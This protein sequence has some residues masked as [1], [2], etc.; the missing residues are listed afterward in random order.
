MKECLIFD[1]SHLIFRSYH[2][3][4]ELRTS[5][6]VP[7]QALY[8]VVTSF[9]KVVQKKPE[10][11]IVI[12]ADGP[13]EENYRKEIY[14]EY[15]SNRGETPEDLIPQFQLI[16]DFF[17]SLELPIIKVKGYEADD[18]IASFVIQNKNN[19]DRFLILSEDK[20]LYQL[21]DEKTFLWSL[22]DDQIIDSKK[23]FEK[24]GVHPHQM[25]DYLTLV[26]DSSDHIPG[27]PGIGKEGA[28]KLLQQFSTLKDIDLNQIK[29]KKIQK[30][31]QEFLHMDLTQELVLLK[32][33]LHLLSKAEQV[34]LHLDSFKNF[35]TN[36]EF[37]SLSKKLFK[38]EEKDHLVFKPSLKNFFKNQENWSTT[39]EDSE[40]I[41]FILNKAYHEQID[42]ENLF[43]E[44]KKDEKLYNLYLLEK[45]ISFILAK[46]ETHGILINEKFY[47]NLD[48]EWTQESNNLSKKIF[49]F[50]QKEINLNSP[51]QLAEV[52]FQEMKFPVVRKTKTGY[53]TDSDVLEKLKEK[54]HHEIFDLL[55]QYREIE[56]LLTT[57][58][59]N[60]LQLQDEK[61]RLHPTFLQTKV[62][63]G[64][65][66][67]EK[68]N[69]QNIPIKSS[70]GRSL[71]KGFIAPAHKI[72]LSADY[73]QIEL[74]ILAHFSEDPYLIETFQKDGDI[75][76]ATAKI[77]FDEVDD[78]KRNFAKMINFSL[79]YGQ[80]AQSLAENL[81]VSYEEAKS[82]I[83]NYFQKF[84][85]VK[86]FIESLKDQCRHDS[87]VE[88]LLGRRRYL[89]EINSSQAFIRS[90]AERAAVN[91][92]IQGTAADLI[93]LSMIKI[94]EIL[95]K[96][97]FLL[98]QIHDELI[99]ECPEEKL[100]D[101]SFQVK[102]IMESIYPLKIPLKVSL[103]KG[104]NLE[105]QERI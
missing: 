16:E 43:L 101:F 95:P 29:N 13:R 24:F 103:K 91:T 42:I 53:S 105:E 102:K 61:H 8:G 37:F 69:L 60:F 45:K 6:G 56:K 84:T 15:K 90:F 19:F 57:Y 89:P 14:Q 100:Q 12:A 64:R 28:K 32:K 54:T 52:L 98:L 25:G 17:K 104:F 33:D 40:L 10:A 94:Y 85:K 3:L 51:K 77:L 5:Q 7:V 20:D 9:I 2:A 34:N 50:F 27:V 63:T 46:M 88:T 44:L 70:L 92:P 30:A 35:L 79:L 1:L 87:Y 18:I 75:H 49:S 99:F 55:L 78:Q 38:I 31:L 62:V 48:H 66:S 4:K 59:R 67:C 81:K 26:G 36:M 72:F 21:I 22:K 11:F 86:S 41:C 73:S 39:F 96:D 47:K 68:P 80:G 65:L 83:Q 97:T 82:F 71:R 23:V 74:R 58:V 93:K 76:L